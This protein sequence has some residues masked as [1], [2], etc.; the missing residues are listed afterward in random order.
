MFVPIDISHGYWNTDWSTVISDIYKLL[1]K[2]PR[3]DPLSV[4]HEWN[5]P[6]SRDDSCF[7]EEDWMRGFLKEKSIATS[8][9]EW[10]PPRWAIP[11][12]SE[13]L[14]RKSASDAREEKAE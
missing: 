9:L 10:H 12:H 7:E 2:H 5:Q 8:L 6:T 3:F 11:S 13:L 4:I 1:S 14:K